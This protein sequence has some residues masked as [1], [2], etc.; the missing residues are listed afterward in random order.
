[1]DAVETSVP[2]LDS[3]L[4]DERLGAAVGL[5]RYGS[6]PG[7]LAVGSRLTAWEHSR[8]VD[9]RCFLARVMGDVGQA[10]LYQPLLSLLADPNANVRRAALAA[11]G[12]VKHPRLLPLVINSLSDVTTRS[13]AFD[14]LVSYGDSM[15]PSVEK[16]LLNGGLSEEDTVRLV[17][18]CGQ[19]KGEQVLALMK[20]YMNHR[21]DAVRSQIFATLH[22]CNYQTESGEL[23]AVND[24][25]RREVEHAHRLLVARQDVGSGEAVE[26]LGRALGDEFIRAR[27]RVF[28]LLSF[29]YE[30]RPVLRAETGLSHGS[31]TGQALALEMLDVTLSSGHKLLTFPLIDPQMEWDQRI[32]LLG[33]QFD[34]DLLGRDERLLNLIQNADRGWAQPWTRACA[35]YAA[36]KLDLN[37][38]VAAIEAAVADCNPVVQET[39]V[40]AFSLL[41]QDSG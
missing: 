25:L 17:R 30:S 28:L 6:I 12:Q 35:I 3:S 27:R 20:P 7:V 37:E 29:M 32:Q 38:A 10:Y 26:L 23:P 14:A 41:R 39:A 34:N 21:A 11:T 33:R 36:A 5:L 18:A 13:A 31:K 19:V 9:D 15:L 4:S 1:V 24:V 8:E 2:Y 40:W 22:A 16:A